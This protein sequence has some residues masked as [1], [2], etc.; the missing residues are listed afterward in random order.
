MQKYIVSNPGIL[1]LVAL[2]SLAGISRPCLAQ[3]SGGSGWQELFNGKDLSGWHW[4]ENEHEAEVRD[5][6]IV[7]TEV[8]GVPNGFLCTTEYYEDFILELEVKADILME[9]SGIQFRSKYND[10]YNSEL[11]GYQAQIQNCPPPCF[12]MERCHL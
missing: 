8:E 10:E 12:A 2:V 9:N 3:Q 11:Y 7:L 4:V 5:D 1:G 6:M